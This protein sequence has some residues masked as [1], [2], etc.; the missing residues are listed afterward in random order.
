MSRKLKRVIGNGEDTYVWTNPWSEN[1]PLKDRYLS[2]FSICQD[3]NIRA[4]DLA[5][6]AG[7][8]NFNWNRN[9]FREEAVLTEELK[10]KLQRIV[11]N[12]EK[13][14]GVWDSGVYSVKEAYSVITENSIDVER[15]KLAEIWNKFVPLKVAILLNAYTSKQNYFERKIKETRMG[16]HMNGSAEEVSYAK[17]SSLQRKAISLTKPLRDEAIT[18]LYSNTLPK[19]LA[20][21]DLGCSSGPNTLLVISEFIKVVEN[22]CRELNKKSPEYK[23]FLNDLSE[24]DFNSIFMSLDTFKEKL[25]H[26]MKNEIGP[27]YFFGVPGSFYGRTFPDKSLHFVHSS[28]SLHWLSK[29]P[30]GVESNNKGN[31]YHS[32]TSPS[33]VLKAYYKQFQRDFSLFLQCRAQELV[34]GGC[35]ILT[36]P[37]SKE[38]GYIWDLMTIVLNDMVLQG[39]IDEEK[40]DTFNI[41]TYFPTPSELNMEVLEEGSFAIN[42]VEISEVNWNDL[43]CGEAL[44]IESEMSKSIKDDGYY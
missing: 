29:V 20:I 10:E 8:W 23:V 3:K 30:E 13:E 6:G 32:S 19:S 9:L 22:L 42:K 25:H 31:I 40:F 27:C 35:M 33:N 26:E 11:I 43:D 41:Q 24:N 36:V 16:L 37:S 1:V 14:D 12:C 38:S 5:I 28:N 17:N 4:K 2:L 7:Q 39:S 34:E 18:S 15:L 21:A 44:D